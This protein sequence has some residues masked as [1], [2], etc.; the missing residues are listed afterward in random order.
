[1]LAVAALV[2]LATILILRHKASPSGSPTAASAT[3]ETATSLLPVAAGTN[4]IG[5]ATV[6][7]RAEEASL[8]ELIRRLNDT[9]LPLS[10][11]KKAIQALVKIGSP[12]ALAA[13][14]DALAHSADD[15]RL[16]IA[17]SLDQCPGQECEA[18]LLRLLKDPNQAIARAALRALAAANG[19]GAGTALAQVLNDPSAP[20]ALRCDAAQAL[21]AIK[22]SWVLEPL[23]RVVRESDSQ[24]VVETALDVIG[25]LDFNDTKAFF[26][27]YLQNPGVSSELRAAAVEAIANS[28]GDPSS[29]LAQLAAKDPD[30]DVRT[31]AAWALSATETTGNLGAALLEMLQSESDPSVRLRLYQALSNQQSYDLSTALALLQNE[32]DPA[33]RVAGLES[34]ARALRKD[35]TNA[36]LLSFF[37]Q[38]GVKD[39]RQMALNGSSLD[40]QQIAI[41]TLSSL[42]LAHYPPAIDALKEVSQQI[43][44]EKQ[45]AAQAAKDA[46][47][48]GTKGSPPLQPGKPPRTVHKP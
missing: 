1:M 30:P 24:E 45:K 11:R 27:D 9:S 16:A 17:E 19:P 10:E 15:L 29:F 5:A 47:S 39:L 22:E 3:A 2:A 18:M 14:S 44:L 38:I 33:A 40:E 20:V 4:R 35:P 31:A 13:L 6:I 42:A 7:G 32:Q 36:Q 12:E 26:Q 37:N 25:G 41:V 28:Q 21:G 8:P 34:L 43:A 46:Q 23:G 48:A